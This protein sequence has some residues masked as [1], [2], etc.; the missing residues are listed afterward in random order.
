[1]PEFKGVDKIPTEGKYQLEP[2]TVSDLAL[3][4][5]TW[6]SAVIGKLSSWIQLDRALTPNQRKFCLDALEQESCPG[7]PI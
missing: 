3:D 4:S 2:S 7:A 1:M 5:K 6:S